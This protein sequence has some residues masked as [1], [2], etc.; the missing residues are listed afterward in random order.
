MDV[1]A[2]FR[3]DISDMKSKMQQID[4]SLKDI[5]SDT[6]RASGGFTVMRNA[7]GTALGGAAIGLFYKAGQAISSFATGSVQAAKDARLADDRVKAI[8]TSMGVLDTVLGGSTKRLSDYAT[9][10]QSQ[11]GVS[12][13]TIKGAQALIL[14]FKDV[15]SSAGEAGGIFD[16]TTA[17]AV[18]LAAAGFGNVES[19]AKSLARALQ[20]PLKGLTMLGRQGVTFTEAEK[21]KIKALTESGKLLQAQEII[22]A[23]VETQVGGTAA[24]TMTAGDRM[25]VAF[26]E[27]QETVGK[28]VLP[29]IEKVQLFIAEK[30]VPA[31]ERFVAYLQANVLPVA[32][33]VFNTLKQV[34]MDVWTGIQNLYTA[35]L[36]IAPVFAPIIAG[37]LGMVAA[38]KLLT[39]GQ[40]AIRAM[41]M[42]LDALKAKQIALN[43]AILANPFVAVAALIVG[44]V[45]AIAVAFKMIYDR[46]KV[47]RDAVS[48]VVNIF[49]TVVGTI[50]GDVVG[51]FQSLFGQQKKV[52]SGFSGFGDIMQ[53]VAD[54]AGPI[55]AGAFRILGTYLKVA[56]NIVRVVVKAFEIFFT[57]VK[58]VA[59]IIRAVFIMAVQKVTSV[60]SSLMDRLGPVGEALKRVG[61]AVSSAFSNIPA[62]IKGAI[63][64]A[65]GLVEGL[66]NKAIDAINILIRA[67]NAIPFVDDVSEIGAFAFSGFTEGATAAASSANNLANQIGGYASQVMRGNEAVD[68]SF[69]GTVSAIEETNEEL[70]NTSGKGS[71]TDKVL[72][73]LKKQSEQLTKAMTGARDAIMSI[74][75]AVEK[76]FGEE[77]MVEKAFGKEGDISSAIS[78]YDQLDAALRDYYDSLLKAPNLSK[79][80]TQQLE[81]ERD[82]Q[83]AALRGAVADQISLYRER[84]RI[85]DALNDLDR[86][87]EAQVASI[88]AKYDALDK[89]AEENTKR[90]EAHW[91]SIIP[92]LEDALKTANDAF[93]REN[94]VL[95]KLIQDRD[96]YLSQVASSFRGFVNQLSFAEDA[97][98]TDIRAQLES[99]LQ[100]VR[101]FAANIRTLIARGLDPTL[102]QEFVSA[103][104]S[105]AGQAAAALATAGQEEI[106]A[107]NAVQAGLASEIASFGEFGA[108]Q[109]YNAGIAQQQAIVAP[110]QIAAEQAQMALDMGNASRASEL[111][112]AQ[113]HAEQLKVNR[114]AELAQAKADYETQNAALKLQME[115][116][117]A[118]IAEGAAE[119]QAQ[120]TGL[121]ETMP[122]QMHQIGYASANMTLRG[123]KQRYPHIKEQ[124]NDMMDRLA[125]SMK[126]ETTITV[127]TVHRSVF[128][129]STPPGRALGGP[130]QARQA[131]IVG[132]R[133]PELFVSNQAGNIIPNNSLDSI[134]RGV[135]NMMGGGSTAGGT[136]VI[137]MNVTA[138]MGAD[139][140][141]VGRQVVEA[142]RKYER[143]SGP[144][145]VSA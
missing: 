129:G 52:G 112:A 120:F 14:T 125:A 140:A 113:A 16:R 27:F 58:M 142:I 59:N 72:E 29:L 65:V 96:S 92:R 136:T 111:A 79:K 130:V 78:A 32:Q 45:A 127:T 106:T 25:R 11:T 2:R 53:K 141:E 38:Y 28:A 69:R 61:S 66:I 108:Q 81:A 84:Q 57:I 87:Y 17:A 70:E 48:D 21:E 12:D 137:N 86:T 126:R 103:G 9:E 39:A 51:A 85:Q 30:I 101:E 75:D 134:N 74:G 94:S 24:A 90:I 23:S 135:G 22:M 40:N 31:L 99:R 41:G 20:D 15:A 105:G 33:T 116:T 104:V 26:D 83:R 91:A 5:Q 46:S 132:E 138:G 89:A 80:I 110:L 55:L 67:Y 131:Y 54:V 145:F 34:I 10:L 60:L 8:A 97:G 117:N 144:V 82:S 42:A 77:S 76:K 88:N 19:N 37:I 35:L 63:Q 124:M 73:R 95:Q 71:K 109:W 115:Q 47:L 62:I 122:I 107:I 3:A 56:G 93:E 143:R 50:I 49:K 6:K 139:G 119:L 118:A 36:P 68:A 98:G 44:A 4:T 121:R 114:Q 128:E 100:A 7:I 123:F 18:D 64:S 1:T 13:E 133:G 43:A 102:V